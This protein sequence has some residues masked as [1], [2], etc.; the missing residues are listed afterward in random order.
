MYTILVMAALLVGIA[1]RRRGV[2][3]WLIAAV[4]D[5][6]RRLGFTCLYVGPGEGSSTSET[7]LRKRD[8]EFVAT[9]SYCVCEVSIFKEMP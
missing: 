8:W 9:D 6:S 7:T 1:C 4:E 5:T 2:A 3:G